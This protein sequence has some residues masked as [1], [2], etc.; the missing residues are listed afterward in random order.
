[1]SVASAHKIAVAIAFVLLTAWLLIGGWQLSQSPQPPIQHHATED[2]GTARDPAEEKE[3]T[4]EALAH[5][6]WWLTFFTG[7][8]ALATIGF[9]IA[10]A[11]L[12]RTG[13]KQIGVAKEAADAAQVSAQ[14]AANSVQIAKDSL[15]RAYVF[16]GCGQQTLIAA[17]GKPVRMKVTAT[18]GNYGKTTALVEWIFVEH[19]LERDLPPKP[20]YKNRIAVN[21]PLPPNGQVRRVDRTTVE[22]DLA[23]G[24][25]YYGRFIY[26]DVFKIRHHSSFIYRFNPDGSHE[27]LSGVDPEYWDWDRDRD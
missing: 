5:Y 24:Q 13:E 16:G 15:E 4:E 21:D 6:T 11:G 18:H 7:I 9:G 14:A 17:Q 1:M 12:Y 8:L 23:E 22:F 25:I 20:T 10:T 2:R 26:L 19:C 27:P 3:K